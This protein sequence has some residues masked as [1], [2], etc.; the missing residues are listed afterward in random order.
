MVS[1][2]SILRRMVNC[3]SFAA[4]RF[5][6]WTPRYGE[7][8]M[9]CPYLMGMHLSKFVRS[10]PDTFLFGSAY[11]LFRQPYQARFFPIV[12]VCLFRTFSRIC[13]LTMAYR[14][15]QIY[16]PKNVHAFAH[17]GGIDIWFT[18]RASTSVLLF[19]I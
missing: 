18:V 2:P 9:F 16:G 6:D 13:I 17:T 14:L 11:C 8:T 1:S 4:S 10:L 7:E 19:I 15:A 3:L 12:Y 5:P